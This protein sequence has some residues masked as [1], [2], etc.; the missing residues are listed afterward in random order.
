[1]ADV[2]ALID[3]LFFQAK[4]SE[5]ARQLGVTV[6]FAPTGQDL[7]AAAQESGE[8]RL[9]LL[10][11]NA[12]HG[13]LEALETLRARGNQLPVIGFLSHVQVELAERARAA[14]C[15]T[16]LPRSQFTAQLA[17]ILRQAKR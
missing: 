3:D 9:L 12:R 6:Q 8:P 7:L 13:P 10:D 17:S 1:M 15:Q 16:V 4:L 14:G 5:T 11:L 2:L